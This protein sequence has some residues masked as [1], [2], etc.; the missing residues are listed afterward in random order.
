[1]A[2]IPQYLP[3]GIGTEAGAV[4][5]GFL[6][7]PARYV[8]QTT[9]SI[10]QQAD[11]SEL[12][13]EHSLS[14]KGL[15]R[16]SQES[17]HHG[18]GQVLLDGKTS[19]TAADPERYYSS[20]GVDPWTPGQISLV[21][22]VTKIRTMSFG[23]LVIAGDYVYVSDSS[24][25]E[26]Y[27]SNNP[28][29]T[30]ATWTSSTIHAGQAAQTP[31]SLATNGSYV[32]AALGSSGLHRT[33]VGAATST[34]DVPAQACTLVGYALGRLLIA[35]NHVLYEVDA[36]LSAPTARV[37]MTHEN[38]NF[39]WNFIQPGR[40]CIYAGGNAGGSG[41][42]AADGVGSVGATG[43]VYRLTL[44]PTGTQLGAP[45]QAT[46]LPDGESIYNVQF[47]AGGILLSTGRGFRVGVADSAGNIDSGPLIR[48]TKPVVALEPQD[49][50]A[51]WTSAEGG[52]A[53]AD[54]GYFTDT[55]TPA[56]ANDIRQAT[57]LTGT[58]Q[59]AGSTASNP[60]LVFHHHD[61]SGSGS[62]LYRESVNYVPSGVFRTGQI[63]FGTTD[64]KQ[65]R[66]LDIKFLP[67]PAGASIAVE[68]R[69]LHRVRPEELV[70][71]H[72]ACEEVAVLV[73][74]QDGQV[75]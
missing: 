26:V 67:L 56:W 65:S 72:V 50:Y 71:A 45:V 35:N 75:V 10:R 69:E 48:S 7:D 22:D 57:S 6:L 74:D 52:L 30:G 11:Q 64:Q 9:E 29:T 16:R 66:R 41:G 27:W 33:V 49:R 37:L 23:H 53:R 38:T 36:P 73:L 58:S 17:W 4:V 34:A 25:A 63:R 21:K 1:M 19:G 55:L 62:G 28:T 42:V 51:W 2:V 44:E 54:L 20:S 32:W 8:V 59:S 12:P 3:A 61:P 43:E 40:G 24:D 31:A 60:S 18:A 14:P 5:F 39:R 68:I 46:Y 15:W 13:G 70:S 47:Y